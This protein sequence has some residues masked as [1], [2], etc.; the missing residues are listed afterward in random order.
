[1]DEVMTTFCRVKT[2]YWGSGRGIHTRKDIIFLKRKSTKCIW[3]KEDVSNIGAD[4]VIKRIT[5]LHEVDDGIYEI[6]PC[7]EI[8]DWELGYADDY[9]YKLIK[10]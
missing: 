3:V 2:S 1:M 8:L 4:E 6:V 7:N 9:E 10:E 5:N